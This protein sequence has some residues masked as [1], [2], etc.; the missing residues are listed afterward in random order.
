ME[1]QF[2]QPVPPQPRG[3]NERPEP[4]ENASPAGERGDGEE[5]PAPGATHGIG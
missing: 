2:P 4:V 5:I 3:Q 1:L